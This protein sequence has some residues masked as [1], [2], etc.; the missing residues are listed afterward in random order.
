LE[1]YHDVAEDDGSDDLPLRLA[2][3]AYDTQASGSL[4]P[5]LT[6]LIVPLPYYLVTGGVGPNS[7]VHELFSFHERGLVFVSAD[8]D[9]PPLIKI[10]HL[11]ETP[12]DVV[13]PDGAFICVHVC[14]TYPY[15]LQ[16]CTNL[17]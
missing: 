15:H 7:S 14:L 9:T 3:S 8:G 12:P 6:A 17:Q 1:F 5:L 10:V 16:A 11:A 13:D 4:A 2:Y